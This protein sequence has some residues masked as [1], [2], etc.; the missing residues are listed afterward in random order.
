[1]LLDIVSCKNS[2][3]SNYKTDFVL[4]LWLL[5]F[6][7]TAVAVDDVKNKVTQRRQQK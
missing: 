7:V 6:A 3:T 5:L 4:T 1:M 2:E